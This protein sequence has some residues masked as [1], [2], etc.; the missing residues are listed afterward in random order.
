MVA[1]AEA[2]SHAAQPNDC[3]GCTAFQDYF[4]REGRH[5][6]TPR[7]SV[8]RKRLHKEFRARFCPAR[9][10]SPVLTASSEDNPLVDNIGVVG[11]SFALEMR[12][13]R[14]VN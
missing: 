8:E 1:R 12:R 4:A 9:E 11:C 3:Y 2:T 6:G 10:G 14:G 7:E 13:A 5:I